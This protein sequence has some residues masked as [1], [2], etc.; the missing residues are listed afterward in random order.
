MQE[1]QNIRPDQR[2]PDTL[3]PIEIQP[4]IAP[5]A[6]GSALIK[7]GNTQVICAAT[8]EKKLPRWIRQQKLETG[9]ISA[10]YSMLP[11][12]T[13]ERKTRERTRGKPES[14]SIEIQRFIGRALRAV[15]DLKKL[16]GYTLWIDCDVLEADGGTRTASI[17]G[18][19][20]A[21]RLA[22]EKL[23]HSEIIPQSPFQDTI[24]AVS[25][26]ILNGQEILDLNYI[27]DKNATVDFNVV[28]TGK[29]QLV[30]LQGAGEE[31]TFSK[32][33]LD[34]LLLLAK[35]GIEQIITLQNKIIDQYLTKV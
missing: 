27:E 5:N 28:M 6:T 10:E 1:Q 13:N 24:A 20:I 4:D 18:S 14:R 7:F 2:Y 32:E 16:Q 25:V 22:I 35:K 26:G 17:S 34:K 12:S 11:Y 19:Y 3:R 33:Q 30:E 31:T 8:I 21:A 15:V 29:G 23:I 9:W